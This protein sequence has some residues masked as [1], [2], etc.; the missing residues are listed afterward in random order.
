MEGLTN[1]VCCQNIKQLPNGLKV[2][3][4]ATPVTLLFMCPSSYHNPV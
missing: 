1:M 4:T 2:I 3:Y